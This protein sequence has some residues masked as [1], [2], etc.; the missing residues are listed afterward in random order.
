MARRQVDS[1]QKRP[2]P[3]LCA[4]KELTHEAGIQLRGGDD[5]VADCECKGVIRGRSVRWNGKRT[6]RPRVCKHILVFW[7][8]VAFDML[9]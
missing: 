1:W 2:I 8:L 6:D 9:P 7:T 4:G 5:G 3:Y